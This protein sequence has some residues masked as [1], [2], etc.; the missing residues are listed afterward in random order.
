MKANP[1]PSAVVAARLRDVR[2]YVLPRMSPDGAEAVLTNG[3]YVRSVPR[4]ERPARAHAYWRCDD[5]DGDGLAL[6]MRVRDAGGEMVESPEFPGLLLPRTIDDP[7]PYYKVYP[8]GF[9]ENFDGST[10]PTP[11]FLSDNQTDLNRN[12]PFF[13]APDSKQEGAGAFPLSEIES[14]AVVEFAIAHPE[15][16]LWLNLH[17]FGGVFIRPLGDKPD[18]KMNPEDLALFRQLVRGRR[19]SPAIRWSRAARN[20]CTSPIR[21]CTATSP[22]S[23]ITSA[24]PSLT[25]SSCGIFS[26]RSGSS[27]RS[28]SSTTTRN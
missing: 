16:F 19:R 14:R 3:R 5:V 6:T 24:A 22:I 28:A 13:W 21:R 18:S 8:E 7:P 11:H 17:T 4:D 2:F 20:S 9:V 1:G 23:P 10:V 25:S 27:A 15:I 26:S 12:F